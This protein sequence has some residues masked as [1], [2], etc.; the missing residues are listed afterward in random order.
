V[1][2]VLINSRSALI[3][4]L[5]NGGS[6]AFHVAAGSGHLEVMRVLLEAGADINGV[7]PRD[8]TTALD[9]AAENNRYAVVKM[10]LEAQADVTVRDKRG[11]SA[12]LHLAAGNG[13]QQ[14]VI[15]LLKWGADPKQSNK[16]GLK[17]YKLASQ[18]NHKE[19]AGILKNYNKGK[20]SRSG[21]GK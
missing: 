19:L 21:S 15:L 16:I 4:Q 7:N 3:K 12:A 14:V 8:G 2:K 5:A 9:L 17:P 20:L 13:H 1:A 10:L 11:E 6:T 18:A